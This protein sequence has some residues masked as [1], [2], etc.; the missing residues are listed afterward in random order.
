MSYMHRL[1]LTLVDQFP[2]VRLVG[3]EFWY[4]LLVVT[5]VGV[6]WAAGADCVFKRSLTAVTCWYNVIKCTL[7]LFQMVTAVGTLVIVA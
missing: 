7:A 4:D 3:L 5:F 2:K 1:L 6:T